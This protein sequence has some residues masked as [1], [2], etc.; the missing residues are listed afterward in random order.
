MSDFGRLVALQARSLVWGLVGRGRGGRARALGVALGALALSG[1]AVTYLYLT[2]SG[3]VALGLAQ[4]IPALAAL[5]GSL[6][7]VA[8]A[9]M[10]A[11]GTLFDL[12][13]YDFVAALP[14]PTAVVVL[15]RM[16]TLLGSGVALSAIVSAPLYVAYF[17]AVPASAQ[18]LACAVLGTLV[19]PLAPVAVASLA[20]FGV[21]AVAA[22]FRHAG[23]AYLVLSLALVVAIIV[24]SAVLGAVTGDMDA[25]ALAAAAGGAAA[26]LSSSVEA[27]YPPAAWLAAAVTHGSWAGLAAFLGMSALVCAVT[28]ALV[29]RLYPRMGGTV[30]ARGG[31]SF[32]ASGIRGR[33]ASPLGALVIKELRRVATLPTYALNCCVGLVLMVVLAV[34]LGV[35]G[36]EGLLTSG[37]IDGVDVTAEQA[38]AISGPLRAAL[39]WAFGFC[40]AM[41]LT[42]APSVSLEGRSA[43]V[44]ASLPLSRRT[45]LGAKLLANLTLG[46]A[47]VAVSTVVLL[48]CGRVGV[49]CALECA[50]VATGMLAGLSGLTVTL[51][52][53]RPNFGFSSPNEVVKRG[54]PMMAGVVVGLVVSFGCAFAAFLA[55]SSLGQLAA[56]ALNVGVP[57]LV[58]AAG[59]A[60]FL[61]ET[62]DKH[63]YA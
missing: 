60:A 9:F 8:F 1:L 45:V 46:G 30:S 41:S 35:V 50:V 29:T 3:L 56:D 27:A 59:M 53:R 13:D 38:A 37:A 51:D 6:A 33:V 23:V 2:G 55:S 48:A 10:K 63:V 57:A 31:R 14:V 7:G 47:V 58:A 54:F 4:T 20:A 42:A 34:A 36:L 61:R 5:A 12:R 32:S 19:A 17:G 39:P 18:A 43:W 28:V 40:A 22:R 15:A 24:G 16:A 52:A 26:L 44:M 49:T 25:A 62:S 21:S 11:N